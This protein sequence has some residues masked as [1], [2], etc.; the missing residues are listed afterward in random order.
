MDND[1]EWAFNYT[2]NRLGKQSSITYPSGK[3][4]KYHYNEE[5]F[6]DY[7]KDVATGEVIW[8]A[9]A[10]DRWDNISDFT[11]GDIDVSYKYN[12]ITGL[13]TDIEAK[14]NNQVLLKQSY[15]WTVLGNLDWRTDTTIDLKERFGYDGY[16]RLT[17]VS[18][19]NYLESLTY[20][21]QSFVYDP[22]GNI[23]HKTGAGSYA[24]GSN[25]SPYA[26]TGIQPET[27][28]EGL[29]SL[30]KATYTSFDKLQTLMQDGKTLSIN[31]GI[32]RQR[33]KQTFSN[34]ITTRTK[35]YFTPLYETVTENGITKKLHY[36]TSGTGLFAIFASYNNG[37]G[38]MHYTMKD[39]QGNLTATVCGNTVELLSCEGDNSLKYTYGYD[40]QRIHMADTV[41][42]TIRNK[43][44]VG[45]CE[46]IT[47]NDGN[48][49]VSK[50]LTYLVDPFGVFAVVE[51]QA[52]EESIHYVL[53]DNLGSWTTITDAEGNVEQELSFD[54]WGNLRDPMTWS[55]S[56]SGT[57]M[58]DR[59]YTGHEH[60]TGFGLINMNG[61]CYDPLTSSFLSVDAY[62]QDPTSAQAFNRYAYCG[63]NPLRYTDPTGWYQ[64]PGGG[65]VNP[66][67]NTGGHTQY[68]SDDP[69]D[70]LWGR[71]S[72]PWA[73]SSSGYVNG[74]TSTTTLY[75]QGNATTG[76]WYKDKDGVIKYSTKLKSSSQ[77]QDGQ[78]FCGT[79][80]INEGMYYSLVGSKYSINSTEGQIV[81]KLE[82]ESWLNYIQYSDE[83][84][85]YYKD[86]N[87]NYKNGKSEP[88]P[89]ITNYNGILEYK[90]EGDN[91]VSF[92]YG[93][94][95]LYFFV[96]KEYDAMITCFK[97]WT[98]TPF[99]RNSDKV[100]HHLVSGY[101]VHIQAWGNNQ[102]RN[103]PMSGGYN[104]DVIL[105]VYPTME[106]RNKAY[107]LVY[108]K[109]HK[110]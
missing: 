94:A 12:P 15:Y 48:G 1:E 91:L 56:F 74:T 19:K 110:Q 66:N 98:N 104:S 78:T 31:Y 82:N 18:T 59:G 89:T 102:T 80:F 68:Y 33:V 29:F 25:A 53:K 88:V 20:S 5:G 52:D 23:T 46:Y 39:H 27:G 81:M 42:G 109:Y 86:Y 6:M 65:N 87:T 57:P 97:G 55:G 22:K 47:E 72:H 30:Q 75:V 105:L 62:V 70:M 51:R 32:D 14:R 76:N 7:V 99:S 4:I 77:L 67:L 40:Q 37:G 34:G 13:V 28:Q 24:Y 108:G 64:R 83:M 10:S 107:S 54:A 8:Q 69:N 9:N 35:R 11:E 71:T 17:S 43:E 58:F 93:E 26:V 85:D 21:S 49:I 103:A 90:N 79:C 61:R 3:K 2:Y 84:N 44:Y 36:L 45:V 73:N 96:Y 100:G 106:D 60:M 92:K 101:D 50:T 63:Y 16:N 38:T 41:D 95:V